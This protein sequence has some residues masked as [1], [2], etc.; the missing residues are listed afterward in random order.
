MWS[1]S[2]PGNDHKSA[3]GCGMRRQGGLV[4]ER[5]SVG[6]GRAARGSERGGPARA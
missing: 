5:A 2:R 3:L 1:F 4:V 6:C